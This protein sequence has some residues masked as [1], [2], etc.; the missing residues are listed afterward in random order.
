[1]TSVTKFVAAGPA[2]AVLAGPLSSIM[3]APLT[4]VLD[5]RCG[6][7]QIQRIPECWRLLNSI[8]TPKRLRMPKFSRFLKF[9]FLLFFAFI[10]THLFA[11]NNLN[12]NFKW[13]KKPFLVLENG[14][15]GRIT[16][17]GYSLIVNN[18]KYGLIDFEGKLQIDTI[19]AEPL[20]KKNGLIPVR[21][22]NYI[23]LINLKGDSVFP[24]KGSSFQYIQPH[25]FAL[26]VQGE[27]LLF[28]EDGSR[29]K[30]E[31]LITD[32]KGDAFKENSLPVEVYL[33]NRS[34]HADGYIDTAGSSLM[35]FK[36]GYHYPF[37]GGIAGVKSLDNLHSSFI[38]KKGNI[39][40]ACPDSWIS[41]NSFDG[42]LASI[43][44]KDAKGMKSAFINR[45]YKIVTD[46]TFIAYWGRRNG[47]YIISPKGAMYGAIDSTGKTIVP[48][49][50]TDIK[51]FTTDKLIVRKIFFKNPNASPEH[52]Y[53]AENYFSKDGVFDLTTRTLFI[54]TE[55]EELEN[56]GN[57]LLIARSNRKYAY[58]TAKGEPLSDFVFEK[59]EKFYNKRAWV[60]FN[61]KW[62]LIEMR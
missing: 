42:P 4:S 45:N 5:T 24:C 52:L 41:V 32:I 20:A 48:F 12:N 29:L 33:K 22:G 38:D 50:F 44:I 27:V 8:F 18:R 9:L 13:Y 51:E 17:D 1:M 11:Q 36:Y 15:I 34:Q 49:E 62:G 10:C 59:A 61:G 39:V 16:E 21:Q 60:K 31:L 54:P 6:S 2:C 40:F 30:T 28:R 56:A 3:G 14:Y 37:D 7:K 53:D 19:S 26:T 55:C 43:L 58:V 35:E 25:F 23:G 46:S 47:L 57:G